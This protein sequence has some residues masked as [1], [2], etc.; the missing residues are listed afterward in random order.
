M[1]G[2]ENRNANNDKSAKTKDLVAW[3]RIFWTYFILGCSTPQQYQRELKLKSRQYQ[4][5]IELFDN[6]YSSIKVT[7]RKEY[8]CYIDPGVSGLLQRNPFFNIFLSKT[9][10]GSEFSSLFSILLCCGK[11]QFGEVV[12]QFAHNGSFQDEC[13]EDDK[14]LRNKICQLEGNGIIIRKG[15]HRP[16]LCMLSDKTPG[17][18]FLLNEFASPAERESWARHF[19]SFLD[20]FSMAGYFGEL[21]F[22]IKNALNGEFPD[23]EGSAALSPGEDAITFKHAFCAQTLNDEIAWYALLAIKNRQAVEFTALEPDEALYTYSSRNKIIV[24]MLPLKILTSCFKGRRY[25]FGYII[26]ERPYLAGAAM[27]RQARSGAASLLFDSITAI[28]LP[29]TEIELPDIPDDLYETSIKWG[30]RTV[31]RDPAEREKA[32]PRDSGLFE[33]RF[34][35]RIDPENPAD[36][37][38]A[39]NHTIRRLRRERRNGSLEVTGITGDA[40]Y[41]VYRTEAQDEDELQSWVKTYI[42][43]ISGLKTRR[44]RFQRIFLGDLRKMLRL[45]GIAG[46]EEALS[47]KGDSF[48]R[49][50]PED[51]SSK[52][53]EKS[54]ES[55]KLFSAPTADPGI[56]SEYYGIF[57]EITRRILNACRK[58]R[59]VILTDY[60]GR[61]TLYPRK[62]DITDIINQT[63]ESR[64]LK[65]KVWTHYENSFAA[66]LFPDYARTGSRDHLELNPDISLDHPLE[67]PLTRAEL[68]WLYTAL[69]DPLA[70]LFFSAGEY[71]KI[72]S[73]M[74]P[75]LREAND[76]GNSNNAAA[77]LWNPG[78]LFDPDTRDSPFVIVDAERDGDPAA[79]PG[80]ADP[81]ARQ[82]YV[83]NFRLLRQ[84]L[85]QR[86]FASIA[87]TPLKNGISRE[88]G[89]APIR[90]EFSLK[91]AK[92]R[93]FAMAEYEGCLMNTTVNLAT[94]SSVRILDRCPWNPA[95]GDTGIFLEKQN[96]DFRFAVIRVTQ[97]RNSIVRFL[98][99]FSYYDKRTC[100]DEKTGTCLVK[101]L[102]PEADWREILIRILGFGATVKLESGAAFMT[103]LK[104]KGINPD[105]LD[106]AAG[107]VTEE[108]DDCER[109]RSEI[110]AR[111]ER[112]MT[113]YSAG[114]DGSGD[115]ADPRDKPAG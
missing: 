18:V 40:M 69:R 66:M 98:T 23:H 91:N 79:V 83:R 57:V 5:K 26:A 50:D 88:V 12:R 24:T 56:F 4:Y 103:L 70:E 35:I 86:K 61:Q 19:S 68:S 45:Y 115:D 22:Y 51:D 77:E 9:I 74:L 72:Q 52:G 39:L 36:R 101:L 17:R 99:E 93:L 37:D 78:S 43:R 20:F 94:I 60:S 84:A 31:I 48:Y 41:A 76:S 38:P 107:T 54:T 109:L 53:A 46:P 33:I 67:L 27:P 7:G 97:D 25:V 105:R 62:K 14:A 110:R 113:L 3:R 58:N 81:E 15:R 114:D 89:L 96:R 106:F 112:Q 21:G 90:L 47:G 49:P 29:K 100:F 10:A 80:N 73:A 82:S 65:Y 8:E 102:Y 16:P 71:Q 64:G 85:A 59:G 1:N 28:R 44:E 30:T 32:G 6:Y 2:S 42:G 92:F 75:F 13:P 108:Q 11:R 87:Y 55:D 34:H 95:I 63:A 111:L 104:M